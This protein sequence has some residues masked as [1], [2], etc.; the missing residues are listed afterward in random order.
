MPKRVIMEVKAFEE[1]IGEARVG[2]MHEIDK[3]PSKVYMFEPTATNCPRIKGK[4]EEEVIKRLRMQN[5][6]AKVRLDGSYDF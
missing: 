3:G 4:T 5:G 2:W 6:M 1:R